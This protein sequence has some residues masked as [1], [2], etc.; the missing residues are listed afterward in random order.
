MCS[1]QV[2]YFVDV[3]RPDSYNREVSRSPLTTVAQSVLVLAGA[4]IGFCH[5][6]RPPTSETG[7]KPD[8][9]PAGRSAAR[10]GNQSDTAFVTRLELAAALDRVSFR[11]R[12]EMDDRFKSQDH[13]IA[14]LHELT[15]QTGILVER[16]LQR[17]DAT[18]D[19]DGEKR[20]S[21]RR[22]RRQP[23]PLLSKPERITGRRSILPRGSP[24]DKK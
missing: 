7:E 10:P 6:F 17:L 15:A 24:I 11:V 4:T 9:A 14:A 2:P 13:A 5:A 8:T 12:E 3:A 21:R 20:R 23:T 16:L 22:R 18:E 19:G 1:G